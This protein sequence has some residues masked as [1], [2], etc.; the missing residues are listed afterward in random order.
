MQHTKYKVGVLSLCFALVFG[1]LLLQGCSGGITG[2]TVSENGAEDITAD[3][4]V[5]NE[6]AQDVQSIVDSVST[7]LTDIEDDYSAVKE[8]VNEQIQALN[9]RDTESNDTGL[10]FAEEIATIKDFQDTLDG[11]KKDVSSL[12]AESDAIEE[13]LGT[14]ENQELYDRAETYND[15]VSIYSRDQADAIDTLDTFFDTLQ[16]DL[17]AYEKGNYKSFDTSMYKEYT[18]SMDDLQATMVALRSQQNKVNE[19]GETESEE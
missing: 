8:A 14:V 19:L 15:L 10:N 9:K 12:D 4:S 18:Q 5:F 13:W 6:Q 3:L 17:S 2:N 1:V 7:E 11:L 16:D